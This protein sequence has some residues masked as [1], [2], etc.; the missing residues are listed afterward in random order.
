MPR[1]LRPKRPPRSLAKFFR[2][3]KARL[4][5]MYPHFADAEAKIHALVQQYWSMQQHRS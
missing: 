2:R 1:R 5:R 4:R 3:E